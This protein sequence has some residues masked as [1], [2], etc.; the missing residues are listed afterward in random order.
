M[1]LAASATAGRWLSP[2]VFDALTQQQRHAKSPSAACAGGGSVHGGR[3]CG[4]CAAVNRHILLRHPQTRM[5]KLSHLP[6]LLAL[7]P[8]QLRRHRVCAQ[9]SVSPRRPARNHGAT[10]RRM[11]RQRPQLPLRLLPHSRRPP[12]QR[13]SLLWL[14]RSK[15][16]RVRLNTPPLPQL[17]LRTAPTLPLSARCPLLACL[18][19]ACT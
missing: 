5:K 3:G 9:L 7:R 4:P 10:C 16:A 2:G 18:C 8:L 12:R 13:H 15:S 19:W 1:Q 11:S 17:Q 6:R 14:R